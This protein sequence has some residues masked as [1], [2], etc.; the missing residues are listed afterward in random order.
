MKPP[1]STVLLPG[2]EATLKQMKAHGLKLAIAST[3]THRRIASSFE[4]LGTAMLFDTFVGDDDVVNGKPA[5]DMI[6]EAM[7]RTNC[8]PEQTVMIG[9]SVSDMRMGRNAKVLASIGVLTG[10]TKKKKLEQFADAIVSSV[11]EL[12]VL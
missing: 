9:D 8:S 3:D 2:V 6:I 4:T 5:P 11:A 10:S 7:K 12:R 1:F